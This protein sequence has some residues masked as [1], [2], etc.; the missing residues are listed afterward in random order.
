MLAIDKPFF[1]FD[2]YIFGLFLQVYA[3]RSHITYYNP[4]S[5]HQSP[6]GKGSSTLVLTLSNWH[7]NERAQKVEKDITCLL[8]DCKVSIKLSSESFAG[9][10]QRRRRQTTTK[11]ANEYKFDKSGL[12]VD[13]L[14]FLALV[15]QWL[16][17]Q[18]DFWTTVRSKYSTTARVAL[19]EQ[20]GEAP[21]SGND[22]RARSSEKGKSLPQS[23]RARFQRIRYNGDDDDDDEDICYEEGNVRNNDDD[24]DGDND[25]DDYDNYSNAEN[26][27]VEAIAPLLTIPPP[28]P[29][30]PPP[31]QST[32]TRTGKTSNRK[33]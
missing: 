4:I 9:P 2:A 29:P 33:K 5:T 8:K 10:S 13:Y 11:Q 21:S 24:G 14:A 31:R 15:G 26:V 22:K 19:N 1:I 18:K 25:D 6:D 23:K 16:P 20:E 7:F 3:D 27:Y 32:S 12:C 28:P 30:S 17:E